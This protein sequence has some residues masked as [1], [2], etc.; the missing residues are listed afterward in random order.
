VR[1]QD[2]WAYYC[3]LCPVATAESTL[4]AMVGHAI[5]PHLSERARQTVDE[6]SF[7]TPQ[8]EPRSYFYLAMTDFKY[9]P[10]V[11]VKLGILIAVLVMM[12]FIKRPFCRMFCPLGAIWSFFNQASWLRF[13]LRF[14]SC[15]SCDNCKEMCPVDIRVSDKLNSAEC[16]RCL[17]C[18]DCAGVHTTT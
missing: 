3:S 6:R 17:D 2:H 8:E 14:A 13:R 1:A 12:V 4:P 11:A 9:N 10:M 5:Y 16:I 15:P 18:L 7:M